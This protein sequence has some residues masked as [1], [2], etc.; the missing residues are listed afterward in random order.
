G[1][2]Y[3]RGIYFLSDADSRP[4]GSAHPQSHLWDNGAN[5]ADELQRLLKVRARALER[6]GENTIPV[7]MPYSRL[8]DVLVPTYLLHRYQTEAAAKMLGGL[9][10]TYA[11]RGDGQKITEM[12]PAA[13]QK[14]ALEALLATIDPKTLTLPESVLRLIPPQAHGF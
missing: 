3:K 12:V 4:E 11:T 1:E 14:K 10:Y 2:A 8:E 6:F 13:D 7:R 5:A 9:F